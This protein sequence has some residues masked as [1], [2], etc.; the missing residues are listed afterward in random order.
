MAKTTEKVSKDARTAAKLAKQLDG[1]YNP[2]KLGL[3]LK[4]TL[5]L[6]FDTAAFFVA[7]LL[8]SEHQWTYFTGV[9]IVTLLMNWIYIRKGGLPAK[10]LAP[11]VLFLIC[12]SFSVVVYSGFIAFTNYGGFHNGPKE[13]SIRSFELGAMVTDTN[14][15]FYDVTLV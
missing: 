10:Y 2:S 8:I 3:F 14:A 13:E 15:A 6:I 9:L 1:D 11:G 5:L 7:Q 12:F 4:Y